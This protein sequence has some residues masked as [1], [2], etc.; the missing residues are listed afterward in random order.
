M[1]YIK[2]EDRNTYDDRLDDLCFALEE[3]GYQEGH[4]TY[5]LYMIV[6]RWFKHQPGYKAICR[7][8]GCL[9]GT[10]TE[11]D[12]RIAA[13]YEDT[14]IKEN[15]DVELDYNMWRGSCVHGK[16]VGECKTCTKE[17]SDGSS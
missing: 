16:R 17:A 8:R 3:E 15:K 11:F 9:I 1:P 5:V 6:A 14:K 10:M 13:P 4:V 7:I 12:R 2:R